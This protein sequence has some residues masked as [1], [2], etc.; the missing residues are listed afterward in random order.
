MHHEGLDLARL[1]AEATPAALAAWHRDHS[2]GEEIAVHGSWLGPVSFETVALGAG[3]TLV[4]A[5]IG[6]GRAQWTLRREATLP[7][8]V[9]PLL[10][11]LIVG[12][13]PSVYSAE[14]G[15]A[16]ARPGNRFW[17][18]AMAAGLVT[19][20]RDPSRPPQLSLSKP[21]NSE[22]ID[23]PAVTPIP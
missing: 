3:T 12:L 8:L 6:L 16:F 21:L 4:D 14:R 10:G 11:V 7:D 18:A 17:P 19:E 20:D 9:A 23:E 1:T 15:V 5:T 2:V 13:N 22:A